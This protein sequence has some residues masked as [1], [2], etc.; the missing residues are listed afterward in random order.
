MTAQPTRAPVTVS[1][2]GNHVLADLPSSVLGPTYD[3]DAL[4]PSVVHIGVGGFHRAHQAVYFDDLANLG[5]TDWGVTGVGLRCPKMGRVLSS[6]EHLYLV[7]E[8]HP[9][10]ERARVIG[11]MGQHLFAPDGPEAVLS[12]LADERTRLVTLTITDAAYCIDPQSG[13]FTPDQATLADLR[14]EGCPTSVF[15]YL[16]EALARR[17]RDGLPPFTVLSCDNLRNNGS[18]ARTA[19]VSCARL[20]D[21][22]LAEWIE[23]EGAFPSSMVDRITPQTTAEDRDAIVKRHGVDDRWP[24]ITEPFRQWVVEDWFCNGRPPLELVGVRFVPDVAPYAQLKT[25][26]LNAAHCALGH[27]GYLGGYRSTDEV[28]A[29]PL[30]RN[31]LS[32]LMAEEIVPSLEP[33]PDIDL[34]A[35][36]HS[37]LTRLANPRMSDRLARLRR[38][39]TSKI[40]NYVVPSIRSALAEGRT[41]DLLSLAVAA[42]IRFPVDHDYAEAGLQLERPRVH[43]VEQAP[44]TVDVDQILADRSTF[45]D[46]ASDARFV[47]TVK[48]QLGVL[49]DHGVRYAL[50]R[51]LRADEGTAS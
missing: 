4:V 49:D 46:L 15:G 36:Q 23:Q 43:L 51:C 24:V 37:I 44:A 21:A 22:A 19:V 26:L 39:G 18:A 12:V 6:Q 1:G 28:M 30:F 20:R 38:R 35:Y 33:V 16:V 5:V 13:E 10:H 11:V 40:A 34:V 7:V 48:R 47:T 3:R 50:S 8:R 32:A 41:L 17:R 29:D 9:T 31:Y 27:L 25:R 42:W 14:G 2:L 45:G